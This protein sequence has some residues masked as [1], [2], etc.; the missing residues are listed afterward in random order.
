MDISFSQ[1]TIM[2]MDVKQRG[3]IYPLLPLHAD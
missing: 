1:V 3:E 2:A